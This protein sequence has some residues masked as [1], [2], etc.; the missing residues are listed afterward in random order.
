MDS[1]SE[2]LV[3]EAQRG[4]ETSLREIIVHY[5]YEVRNRIARDISPQWQ[6]VLDADDV[7]QVTYLEAFLQI[8]QLR[9]CT[10]A[11]LMTW[12]KQIAQ[13]NLRDAIRALERPKRPHPSQ[14][15]HVVADD[16]SYVEFLEMLGSSTA[17]PS[18][19]AARHEAK[20]LVDAALDRLPPDYGCAVRL[21]DLEGRSAVE[22]A[23]FMGRSVGAVHMLRS[24][25]HE[26]LRVLLGSSSKFFSDPA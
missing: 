11:G 26:R 6:T 16:G 5:G 22:V 12:L 15:V 9:T 2:E 17:T 18:R 10:P 4:D 13:N 3:E 8:N 1:P 19:Q 20:S 7:M 25:A 21:Y 14:R 23:T 24:R